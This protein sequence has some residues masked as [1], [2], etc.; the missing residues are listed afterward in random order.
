MLETKSRRE[1]ESAEV[2]AKKQA[3]E[4]WCALA[5]EH[6][7]RHGGKRWRYALIPHDVVTDNMTLEF[8][9]RNV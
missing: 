4:E 9:S 7:V 5:S 3:A 1:L 6:A 8:L 2:L